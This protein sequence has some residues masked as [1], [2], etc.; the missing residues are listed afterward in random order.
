MF[1]KSVALERHHSLKASKEE[2]RERP[3]RRTTVCNK[4]T[5]GCGSTMLCTLFH[6]TTPTIT[7]TTTT[8]IIIRSL[9][10]LLLL[11]LTCSLSNSSQHCS[12][13]SAVCATTRPVPMRLASSSASAAH[14]AMGLDL[15][16]AIFFLKKKERGYPGQARRAAMQ[17]VR[18]RS[19][20]VLAERASQRLMTPCQS[21]TAYTRGPSR[22]CLHKDIQQDSCSCCCTRPTSSHSEPRACYGATC[23]E[24]QAERASKGNSVGRSRAG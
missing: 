21:I 1:L 14:D 8:I 22:S 11:L 7:T 17:C 2:D 20:S 9:L 12:C 4:A 15:A 23:C 13:N 24:P 5:D 18:S 10:S 19:D 3:S 6:H 16:R